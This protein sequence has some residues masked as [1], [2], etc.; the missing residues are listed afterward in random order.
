M[1][2]P[3]GGLMEHRKIE[4]LDVVWNSWL[5]SKV[6]IGWRL[7]KDGLPTREQLVKRG[8]IAGNEDSF[9]VFGCQCQENINNL[10]LS[11]Q[12]AVAVWEKI[13]LWLELDIHPLV[14][15]SEDLLQMIDI[16]HR[17]R[18]PRRVGAIW[19]TDCRNDCATLICTF[20]G[21][22]DNCNLLG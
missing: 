20:D 3:A 15:C 9:C 17:V 14:E 1:R 5:P 18:S 4:A 12:V 6:R 21:L 22:T 16:L 7:I 13:Y 8:I 10:F 2:N 19:L 11:C